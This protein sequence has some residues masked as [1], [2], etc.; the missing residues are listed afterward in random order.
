[1]GHNCP[2]RSCTELQSP[3]APLDGS[4]AS[5]KTITKHQVLFSIIERLPKCK[6]NRKKSKKK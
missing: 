2:F 4:G 6:H 3:S 5:V 1:M